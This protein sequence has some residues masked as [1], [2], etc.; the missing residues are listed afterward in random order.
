M[1]SLARGQGLDSGGSFLSGG[2]DPP[3]PQGSPRVRVHSSVPVFLF[4]LYLLGKV[5]LYTKPA[6][7]IQQAIN[8]GASSTVGFEKTCSSHDAF[9]ILH[10]NESSNEWFITVE[11]GDSVQKTPQWWGASAWIPSTLTIWKLGNCEPPAPNPGS[12]SP[13]QW[14][15]WLGQGTWESTC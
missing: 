11:V 3:R 2:L 10:L 13:L 8:S 12:G 1:R 7:Q 4:S 9:T 14:G 5:V 15:V 6:S